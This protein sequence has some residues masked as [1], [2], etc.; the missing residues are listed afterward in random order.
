MVAPM[1][2][3]ADLAV[4]GRGLPI[5]AAGLVWAGFGLGAIA[6]TLLGGQIAGRH[7]GLRVLPAWLAVQVAALALALLPAW[8]ALLLAGPMAGFAGIGAT[9]VTLAAARDLAGTR[10][11]V[12]W[13]RA[14]AGYALAQ[15]GFGFAAAALFAAT[16]ESHA[17]VFG[18]GL[19]LSLAALAVAWVGRPR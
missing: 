19:A 10:A 15:A 1:V 7:G 2:Y 13:V 16:G 11:G 17:A 8:P 3:L 4:R 14:T 9:A 12:V 5:E 6:G 18:A